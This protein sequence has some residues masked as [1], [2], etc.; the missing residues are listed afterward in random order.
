[1]AHAVG[2]PTNLGRKAGG[3]S[4][5]PR[6]NR[7]DTRFRPAMRILVL[8]GYYFPEQVGSGVWVHQLALDLKAKGHDVSVLTSFPS[9]PEGRVFPA[10]RGRWFQKE[11][12]DGITVMRTFTFATPS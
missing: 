9:Y 1:M 7:L 11:S 2:A 3:G 12:I 8:A 5:A 6:A 10:Y 4:L